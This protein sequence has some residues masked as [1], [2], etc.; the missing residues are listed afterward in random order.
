MAAAKR[1][2]MTSLSVASDHSASRTPASSAASPATAW[3]S[4]KIAKFIRLSGLGMT[5]HSRT[6][7]EKSATG[8]R[9][10]GL[11]SMMRPGHG[12]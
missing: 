7:R 9:Q 11:L 1:A 2:S 5:S 6:V 12:G 8:M 10:A 3:A 4:R